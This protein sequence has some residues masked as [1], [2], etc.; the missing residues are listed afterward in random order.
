MNQNLKSIRILCLLGWTA[1]LSPEVA[2]SQQKENQLVLDFFHALYSYDFKHSKEALAA[3][4]SQLKGSLVSEL[5]NS[6]F[7]WWLMMTGNENDKSRGSFRLANENLIDHLG[8]QN[9][10]D[11]TSDE[12]FALVHAYAYQTRFALHKK[13]YIQG[14]SNLKKI[15]PYLEIVLAS[16][17]KNEK[18]ILL[19]GLYHYLSAVTIEER[20]LLRPFFSLGPSSNRKLGYELLGKASQ[21]DHPLIS[22][23]AKY[24][25][26]KINLEVADN[27]YEAQKWSQKLVALF[28]NNLLF[29]YYLLLSL[30]EQGREEA[31]RTE[32][33]NIKRL[34]ETLPGLTSDQ[35][36]FFIDEGTS[37]LKQIK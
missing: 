16:P 27:F 13:W 11:L 34:S 17:E 15:M 37:A 7:N 36:S 22:I 18:F 32:Y 1:M 19:A 25:L 29:H 4:N 24:F 23:E 2:L 33:Q 14:L 3:V 12:V 31:A 5:S 6:N 20:P 28:P 21:S 26:M 8:K 30:V 9:P 10:K 35:R